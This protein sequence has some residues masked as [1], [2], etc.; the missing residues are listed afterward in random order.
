MNTH[1][2]LEEKEKK[3]ELNNEQEILFKR[4]ENTKENMFVTGRAGTGKSVLLR[5]FRENTMKSVIVAAPTGIAAV[6]VK[7]QTI[8]SLFQLPSG[9]CRPKKIAENQRLSLLL[10]HTDVLV[11][12]EISMVRADLLDAIDERFRNACNNDLPFGGKQILVFG[13]CYQLPPVVDKGLFQYFEDVY[14]GYHFFHASSFGKANF[15]IFELTQMF[16]QKDPIFRDILNAIRDGSVHKDQIK[17]LNERCG[18][19]ITESQKTIILAS[20]N[21]TVTN[22]NSFCLQQLKSE[23][24]TFQATITGILNPSKF[25]T[26]E[27]LELKVGARIVLLQNDKERRWNNGTLATIVSLSSQH[28]EK[29]TVRVDETDHVLEKTTWE[30]IKYEYDPV[31]KEVQ[32]Q[33]VSSFTQF[34]VR[35]AWA[36]TIHKSQG[37]TY[38]RVILDLTSSMF[39]PGQLYVALSRCTSLEGLFLKAPIREKDVI[40]DEKIREFM[41]E[42]RIFS[43]NV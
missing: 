31:Q 20:K 17:Q 4:M 28:E 38:E 14:G 11:I 5:Y 9:L 24:H 40:V 13:D 3:M 30:E 33:V 39:A 22:I 1:F 35:L 36:L 7:G 6:N 32:E 43:G 16:R 29:I 34:P 26:E 23:K 37:Q 12:D 25:P 2:Y 42:R 18:K 27:I 19:V 21:D 8:H 15:Q 10:H 41:S